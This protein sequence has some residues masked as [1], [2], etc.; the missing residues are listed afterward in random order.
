M[1]DFRSIYL[2]KEGEPIIPSLLYADFYK[3]SMFQFYTNNFPNVWAKYDLKV[4]SDFEFA[5]Y[6]N[7]INTQLDMLCKLKFSNEEINYLSNIR[8]LK[9]NNIDQLRMFSLNR[10]YIH[11]YIDEHGKFQCYSEGPLIQAS[12]FEI[13]TL[14]IL[15][16]IR[17]RVV[18]TDSDFENG[19]QILSKNIAS[20]NTFA[21]KYPFKFSDFSCRRATSVKWLEHVLTRMST[22]ISNVNLT[23]TSC[24]YYAMKLN[25]PYSGT[26]AHE[27]ICAGQAIC[28]PYDSQEYVLG[29]WAEEYRGDLGIAL[30]DTF[31]AKYFIKKV[32]HKG[33][34]MQFSG[35]RHDS[36]DP[37]QFGEDIIAMYQRYGINPLTK[38]IVFSDCL[39]FEK[40]F[41]LT[42]YFHGR[43]NVVFGIGTNLGNAMGIP[44]L[45]IVMKLTEANGKPVIK[46][47]DSEGKGMCKNT[48][49]EAFIKEH[50]NQVIS[51]CM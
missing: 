11:A 3:F 23:G 38:T 32:F 30:S 24:V 43:I 7:E 35:V 9:K 14:V 33:F 49:Y 46:V 28:H 29:K 50:I 8:F 34:A 26:M 20:V 41:Y 18:L 15:Q 12:M 40:A 27:L 6:I 42:E 16:D 5:P 10:E 25:I 17:S 47:S 36:G 31:G 51:D 2:T 37:I 4:R 48:T 39:T 44:A 19:E 21:S 1:A 22:E 13:Y 45:Q